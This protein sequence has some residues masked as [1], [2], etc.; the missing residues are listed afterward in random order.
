MERPGIEY[1]LTENFRRQ[2]EIS[3]KEKAKI[4]ITLDKVR[5]VLLRRQQRAEE[6]EVTR[7]LKWLQ[8]AAEKGVIIETEADIEELVDIMTELSFQRAKLSSL[9][10]EKGLEYKKTI[11][12]NF[13][14]YFTVK[15]YLRKQREEFVPYYF[16][17]EPNLA[18]VSQLLFNISLDEKVPN[19]QFS[20]RD[21]LR[22]LELE[23][24]S[25][26]TASGLDE[27][28]LRLKKADENN[29]YMVPTPKSLLMYRDIA[30]R[31]ERG[32]P[33]LDEWVKQLR[34]PDIK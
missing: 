22:M 8:E 30:E 13:I 1:W 6:T 18:E 31:I 32:N 23:L 9:Y 5:N 16:L 21:L 10:S 28:L 33:K 27:P 12:E 29:F 24:A 2:K 25:A 3:G 20:A 17:D 19:F 11:R 4:S 26:D 14:S 7:Y 15:A 34:V